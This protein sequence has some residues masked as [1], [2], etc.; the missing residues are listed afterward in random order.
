MT[1]SGKGILD[2]PLRGRLATSTWEGAGGWSCEGI[3]P[4]FRG[5]ASEWI[6]TEW[7]PRGK[8]VCGSVGCLLAEGVHR[9][10]TSTTP[11]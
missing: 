9:E 3:A 2:T 7:V 4:R 11:T 6:I 10:G 1:H 5:L 8:R